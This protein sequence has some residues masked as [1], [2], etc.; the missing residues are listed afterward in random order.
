MVNIRLDSE[1]LKGKF[2]EFQPGNKV[3]FGKKLSEQIVVPFPLDRS[4]LVLTGR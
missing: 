3:P 1:K 4:Y 2:Q